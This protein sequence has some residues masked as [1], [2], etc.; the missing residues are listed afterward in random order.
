MRRR[1][2]KYTPEFKQRAVK[3]V[4]DVRSSFPS[5]QEALEAVAGILGIEDPNT[6]RKWIRRAQL[7]GSNDALSKSSLRRFFSRTHTIIIGSAVTVFGG[8]ALA[9]SQQL[10]GLGAPVD[11]S[12]PHLTVDQVSFSYGIWTDPVPEPFK[13]DIKLLNTGG[14]L[15]AIN[16]ARLVIQKVAT[17]QVCAG[18]GGFPSTGAYPAS[19]PINPTPGRIVNIPISQLVPANGADR[20]DLL[21][22]AGRLPA[23]PANIY[24]YRFHLYLT[25]NADNK[26]LDVGEIVMSYPAAPDDGQYFWSKRLAKNP[27]ILDIMLSNNRR[28]EA[29]VRRC[30]IKDSHALHSVLSLS[31]MRPAELIAIPSRLAY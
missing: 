4:T 24:L 9:Y 2:L 13:I 29:I 14:Q 12:A 16:S 25:Y 28:A 11:S 5:D 21:L 31:G 15:A 26:Q 8:L 22:R 7:S 17:L 19:L 3:M 10:F 6:L 30:N 27:H 1:S 20:F 23:A 18:Q